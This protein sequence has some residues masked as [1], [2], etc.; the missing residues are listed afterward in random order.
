MVTG[1]I[2]A[3]C[4]FAGSAVGLVVL[5]DQFEGAPGHIGPRGPAGLDGSDGSNGQPGPM[6][7]PGPRGFAGEQGEPGPGLDQLNGALVISELGACPPGSTT[8][9][10]SVLSGTPGLFPGDPVTDVRTMEL[11][12]INIH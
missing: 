6:G 10:E 4:G 9:F 5:H 2:A 1:V 3:V 7:L 12:E 11:C 8:A